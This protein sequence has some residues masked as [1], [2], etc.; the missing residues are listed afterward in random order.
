[1]L[2]IDISY[3]FKGNYVDPD[4]LASQKPADQGLNSFPLCLLLIY[5]RK[6]KSNFT[7]LLYTVNLVLVRTVKNNSFPLCTN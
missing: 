2:N 7:L 1:M 4:Q 6:A 3:C 5:I